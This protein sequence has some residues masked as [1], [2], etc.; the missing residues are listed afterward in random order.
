MRA[1]VTVFDRNN[2]RLGQLDEQFRGSLKTM[3]ST[4]IRWPKRSRTPIS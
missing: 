4:R 1:D 2:I 3:Y